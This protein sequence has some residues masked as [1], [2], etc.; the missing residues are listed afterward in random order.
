MSIRVS[1]GHLSLHLDGI[2]PRH[3]HLQQPVLPVEAGYPEV[4]DAPRDVAERQSILEEAILAVI[5]F[6]RPPGDILQEKEGTHENED[7]Y[8]RSGAVGEGR[9]LS[10]C[11]SNIMFQYTQ[12][13]SGVATKPLLSQAHGVTWLRVTEEAIS[14]C[15]STPKIWSP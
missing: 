4:V 9:W 2:Q 14:H 15:G 5:K 12:P 13:V 11:F 3:L 7:L 8:F 6:K 1:A 10:V